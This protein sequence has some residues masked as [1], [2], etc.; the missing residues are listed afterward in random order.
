MKT[1]G[2]RSTKL[3]Y[4]TFSSHGLCK[5]SYRI[6]I[7]DMQDFLQN[8]ISTLIPSIQRIKGI[9]LTLFIHDLNH[10]Y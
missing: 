9:N 8:Y 6:F 3:S 1:E 5:Q 4:K 2:T 7:H 10:V